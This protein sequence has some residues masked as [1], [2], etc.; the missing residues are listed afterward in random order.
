[1]PATRAKSKIVSR[2]G[3]NNP[4]PCCGLGTKGCS[5]TADD[6]TLCRGEPQAGWFKLGTDDAGF[7]QCRREDDRH[8]SNGAHRP[9][10]ATP[11]TSKNWSAVAR[12]YAADLTANKAAE[13]AEALGLPVDVLSALG[14]GYDVAKQ[15]WTVPMVDAEG[16]VTGINTRAANGS[17]KMQYGGKLGLYVPTGWADR[18]GP[19]LLPEGASDVLALTAVGLAAVGRP[20]NLAGVDHLAG[21]LADFPAG[22][23]IVVVGERDQKP[24]GSWPGRD[25]AMK[26]AAELARRLVRKVYWSLPP[27]ETKDARAWVGPRLGDMT[28]RD[29]LGRELAAS[30]V[31]AAVPVGTDPKPRFEFVNSAEFDTGDY[32]AEWHIKGVLT[33]G[34]PGLIAG[35]PK[36]LKTS[37]AVDAAISI[38]GGRKFLG[39]FDTVTATVAVI[40][41]ESGQR[42]LQETARRV[43]VSKELTLHGLG[44]RLHWCFDLPV[45]SDVVGMTDF[46]DLLAERGVAVAFIDPLYLCLGN[47][48]AKNMFEVGGVLRNVAGLFV[49]RG[50]TPVI[51]HHANRQLPAGEVMEL[52]HIAYSGIDQFARQFLLVSRRE[53][54][55][56]DGNHKLWVRCGGSAGHGGLW[57][58]DVVEGLTDDNFRGRVWEVAVVTTNDLRATEAAKQAATKEEQAQRKVAEKESAV[59]SAIDSEVSKGQ[60][61]ATKNAIR[62]FTKI[63]YR[64]LGPL[65][66]GLTEDAVI[67][68]VEFEKTIGSKATRK[69]TDYTRV[70]VPHWAETDHA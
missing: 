70:A 39:Q 21:L 56:Q 13:L 4:C 28:D 67:E 3:P 60:P 45:L 36:G 34:E 15:T 51:L 17:K 8:K 40:S 23:D 68:V 53:S 38:G 65:L 58:V 18:S 16:V 2:A 32:R 41:G 5:T 27:A 33:K 29:A 46:A 22:R 52:Q 20:S 6:L 42:T 26:T 37:I 54:Y 62:T 1:M 7:A 49:A 64:E 11:A 35:P 59:L 19:V 50:I 69:M 10:T 25:G 31:K 24:D 48:D 63:D 14:V 30:L 66:D 47:V 57:A 55:T 61:A 43:C 9:T 12:G 44:D